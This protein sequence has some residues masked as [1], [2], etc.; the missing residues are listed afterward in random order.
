[1]Q[2]DRVDTE[3]RIAADISFKI[4]KYLEEREGDINNAVQA[5]NECL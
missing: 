3:R 4:A 5:Y 2:S 1:M